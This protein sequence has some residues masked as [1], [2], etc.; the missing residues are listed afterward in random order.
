MQGIYF[1]EDLGKLYLTGYTSVIGTA[2]E[3]YVYEYTLP[4]TT[5]DLNGTLTTDA[6]VVK[7]NAS[8]ALVNA[9]DDAAAATAG[10]PVNALYRNGS[11]VMIRVA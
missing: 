8:L 1:R 7:G 10:V 5:H 3:E 2:G 9:A 11:V 6:L 4:A